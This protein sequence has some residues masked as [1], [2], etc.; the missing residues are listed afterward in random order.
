MDDADGT[1]L[2]L[3]CGLCCDGS[4]F[5]AVPLRADEVADAQRHRV[6][7]IDK[8]E[9]SDPTDAPVAMAQPCALFQ[10]QCCSTYEEWR[11]RACDDYRCGLLADHVAGRRSFASSMAVVTSFREARATLAG[12]AELPEDSVA[13]EVLE[14]GE[15]MAFAVLKVLRHHHFT[16]EPLRASGTAAG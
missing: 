1:Q 8:S 14:T 15:L 6:R 5:R 11:P 9:R 10:D 2:C 4:I 16:N 13:V 3:A 7:F 12:L